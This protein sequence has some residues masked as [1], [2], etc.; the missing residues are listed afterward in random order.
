MRIDLHI[1]TTR[2][3]S[4]SV[5]D[6]DELMFTAKG[7]DLDGICITEHHRIWSPDEAKALSDKHGIAVFRGVEIT[8][9]GGDI[10]VFGCEEI[11]HRMLTPAE[12]KQRVDRVGGTAIAAH[13]FRGFLLFGFGG[14][15]MPLEDAAK[16]PTFAAVHGLEICNSMCTGEENGFSRQVADLLGLVKIGGSDA[17]NGSQVGRCVTVFQDRIENDIQLA[18]AIL[19]G[20]HTVIQ[21]A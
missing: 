8:T 12:L 2:Y 1:H 14:L 10:L 16:N 21:E 18:Q 4:C 7:A 20:R 15:G 11:P 19:G 3:S 9:T 13:P 6:P 5:L 17:H